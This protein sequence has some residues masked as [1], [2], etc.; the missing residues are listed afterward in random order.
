MGVQ[1]CGTALKAGRQTAVAGGLM[2]NGRNH[3]GQFA[4]DWKLQQR[5]KTAAVSVFYG[6]GMESQDAEV[7][8]R[9]LLGSLPSI[10]CM[11]IL[12]QLLSQLSPE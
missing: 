8:T 9:Q 12:F 4:A 10:S 6:C 7:M 3:I 2:W 5:Q 11:L 1:G